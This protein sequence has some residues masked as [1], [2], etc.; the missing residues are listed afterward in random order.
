M[1]SNEVVA[2]SSEAELEL[3]EMQLLTRLI[4]DGK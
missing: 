2:R 4:I 3:Q 1:H